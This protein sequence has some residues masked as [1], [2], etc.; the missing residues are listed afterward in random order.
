MFA[1]LWKSAV[2]I[3]VGIILLRIAGRKSISQ[4]SVTQTV[5]MIS[6]GSIIIQPFIAHNLWETILAAS[7][8]I[9]ALLVMEILQIKTDFFEKLLSG[10]TITIVENGNINQKNL[11]KMRLTEA[12][13]KMRL[14]QEGFGQIKDF[15]EVSLEP[16]GQIGY[17]LYDEAKP[18]TVQQVRFLLNELNAELIQANRR[19]ID[20]T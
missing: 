1:V 17:E 8:F 19:D 2:M 11:K 18:V 20:E 3:V 7:V 10:K 13:L 9:F 6:I 12:Q 16:N 5:I 4:L 14:R 15:K